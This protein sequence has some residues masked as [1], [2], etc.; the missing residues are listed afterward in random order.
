MIPCITKY[1]THPVRSSLIVLTTYY[2]GNRGN[3]GI[4]KKESD[5]ANDSSESGSSKNDK[6]NRIKKISD[7]G[8]Y[9]MFYTSLVAALTAVANVFIILW[10]SGR[11]PV[12]EAIINSTIDQT[13]ND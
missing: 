10:M 6:I 2:Y 7:V 12:I 5:P 4:K 11:N 13:V 3:C 9:Y 8:K 1:Y